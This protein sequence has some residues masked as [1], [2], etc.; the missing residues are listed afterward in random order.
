M[1]V[2]IQKKGRYKRLLALGEEKIAVINNFF[3]QGKSADYVANFIQQDLAEFTDIKTDTLRQQ[4]NR[5]RKE[6]VDAKLVMAEKSLDTEEGRVILAKINDEMDVI[7]E[8]KELIEYQ[9]SRLAKVSEKEAA[10][11]L[12]F[13][14]LQKDISALGQLYRHLASIQ[15]ETGHLKRVPKEVTA[16]V[17]VSST[18]GEKQYYAEV[19]VSEAVQIATQKAMQILEGQYEE[20]YDDAGTD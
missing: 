18:D 4:L 7:V 6:M 17:G 9:K 10:S 20:V 5:Y 12:I 11:P 1:T 16:Q 3:L 2:K 13:S 15:L 19:K 8:L 14:W